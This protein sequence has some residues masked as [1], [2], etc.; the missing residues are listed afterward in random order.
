VLSF[1]HSYIC[2]AST[3]QVIDQ[4]DQFFV[5]TEWLAERTYSAL[6]EML[7]SVEEYDHSTPNLFD[8]LAIGIGDR[9]PSWAV[10]LES[11]F[12]DKFLLV[13]VFLRSSQVCLLR[14]RRIHGCKILGVRS[15]F[16]RNLMGK[17]EWIL[18]HIILPLMN[19]WGNW[20]PIGCGAIGRA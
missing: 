8:N 4:E 1:G 13:I 10:G 11:F 2:F 6:S 3:G 19:F 7:N 14:N 5:P 15:P 12:N 16:W 9:I 18:E 20:T 17:L